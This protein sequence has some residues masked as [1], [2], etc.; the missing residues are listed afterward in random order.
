MSRIK[1]LPPEIARKIA[2]GEVVER[3]LSVVKEL[4]ENALDAGATE[5]GVELAQ[6]GKTLIRVSD[7]GHG[8]TPEEAGLCFERHSTSK[9]A[10]EADL[11]RIKTMGFRGEALP[12]ITAVSRV[13]LK[14]SVDG[15]VGTLVEREAD[16]VI[17]VEEVACPRG[18]IV[19]VRDLFF[20]LPARRK[21]LR[22]QTTELSRITNFLISS[23]QAF[24]SIRFKLRH[25]A[26]EIFNYAPV[27][28]L[29]E[30]LFQIYGHKILER[31]V[32]VDFSE[33]QYQITGFVSRPPQGRGDRTRQ[34]CYIN[35]R[36]VADKLI[37]A[38]VTQ[39]FR[40]W[41]EKGK[42]PESWLFLTIPPEEVDVN[43][44]PAK[45]EVRFCHPQEV[46]SQPEISSAEKV[47]P[48]F[49]EKEARSQ[50]RGPEVLGQFLGL[51]IIAVSA[52][53]LLVIDQH[54]AHE[55]VLYER[56][57]EIY[58]EKSWPRKSPL[59]PIVIELS[60]D[61]EVKLRE[62]LPY[63][64]SAGFRVE[65]MGGK[66]YALQEFPDILSEDEAQETLEVLLQELGSNRRRK[67]IKMEEKNEAILATLACRTAIK[68][69]EI[70]SY[71]RMQYLV[72]ELFKTSNPSLCP[73]GRPI[74]VKLSI[75][76][77][78]KALGRR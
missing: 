78:E 9:I 29:K 18:T 34:F 20:N 35:H 53:G 21:F 51:Y 73:H 7:N 2:A 72:E 27:K 32:E 6:G 30:R 69:G 77:I 17:R 37:L 45:A 41:L 26:K 67:A 61:Q 28:N 38:A 3:P 52:E 62:V 49:Q 64:E 47:S 56:Y 40:G 33:G 36:W 43:V 11:L 23:A 22:S 50:P 19:E 54:N 24:P 60:P 74:L 46:S 13:K 44:H 15:R 75:A 59:F 14:T 42:H 10:S 1:I 58:R 48:R 55:R 4:V 63:L 39:S 5:I 12:S 71:S 68:A 57:L 25:N 8:M 76:E 65:P 31:L 70:L 16:Q 66:A